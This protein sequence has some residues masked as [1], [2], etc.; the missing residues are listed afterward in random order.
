MSRNPQYL[1]AALVGAGAALA[2]RSLRAAGLT[3]ALV[4]VLD[5]WVRVEEEVLSERFGQQYE[6][7]RRRVRRWLTL[8]SA[9]DASRPREDR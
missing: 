7:Y 8:S 5:R 9:H 1:G 2:G 4:V 6:A 3:G